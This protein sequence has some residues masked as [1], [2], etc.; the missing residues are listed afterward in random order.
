MQVTRCPECGNRLNDG[1]CHMCMK[2]IPYASRKK[3]KPWQQRTYSSTH[4]GED[5]SCINFDIP[6]QKREGTNVIYSIGNASQQ[7][8]NTKKTVKPG[9]IA[10]VLGIIY[11]ISMIAGFAEELFTDMEVVT[12]EPDYNYEQFIPAGEA[13]G[14]NHPAI[15][16]QIIYDAG[17]IIVVADGA[18]DYY[19]N[20]A[21]SLTATNQSDRNVDISTEL[22]SVNGFM[23]P[24]AGLYL[25]ADAGDTVQGY[26]IFQEYELEDQGIKQPAQ[27]QFLLGIYD[28]DSYEP[29]EWSELITLDT[30]A[31]APNIPAANVGIWELYNQDG[32]R[33]VLESMELTSY[34]EGS[35]RLYAENTSNRTVLLSEQEI[36]VNGEE[37]YGMFWTILRP[38]TRTVQQVWFGE[39]QE[40]GIDDLSQIREVA[41][42]LHTE[43]AQE[44]SPGMQF[45]E[46]TGFVTLVFNPAE[47]FEEGE[48]NAA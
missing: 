1:Y 34:G 21:I 39:L 33:I 25:Q 14:E 2:Q 38:D 5:H 44:G 36:L 13:G 16:P 27:I 11:A 7:R 3:E 24:G 26:L 9:M 47:L 42:S 40:Q 45:V 15:V 22:V 43:Y 31:A 41:I 8:R 46:E 4:R 6:G 12:P 35:M 37:S 18:G 32:L 29:T 10:V 20:Y 28:T 48:S 23:T 30:D 17:G 19:G